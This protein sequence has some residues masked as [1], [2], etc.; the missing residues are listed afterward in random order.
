MSSAR[1]RPAR[2]TSCQHDRHRAHVVAGDDE[3][4]VRPVKARERADQ[5]VNPFARRQLAEKQHDRR[6]SPRSCLVR[7]SLRSRDVVLVEIRRDSGRRECGRTATPKRSSCVRSDSL[8]ARTAAASL[9]IAAADGQVV[10][11]LGCPTA[12]EPWRRAVRGEHIGHAGRRQPARGHRDRQ[13]PAGV[14]VRDV[15]SPGMGGEKRVESARQEALQ[16]I[17]E[18]VGRVGKRVNVHA[19]PHPGVAWPL[20]TRAAPVRSIC[21]IRR[22]NGDGVAARAQ[23]S[24]KRGRHAGDTTVAPGVGEIRRDVQ[25]TQRHFCGRFDTESPNRQN[26]KYDAILRLAAIPQNVFIG[27][28]SNP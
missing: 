27:S 20:Q 14:Q 1:A 25:Y 15:E 19:I 17:G 18:D 16:M 6:S 13:V 11:P 12:L 22:A 9:Q 10:H 3:V 8:T 28:T 24:G 5:R 23:F 26:C 4:R 21:G 2:S 7:K